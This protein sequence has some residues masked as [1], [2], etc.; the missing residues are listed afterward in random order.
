VTP[1]GKVRA[2]LRKQALAHGL[3]HRKLSWK[4]RVGAP[5]ELLFVAH[6]LVPRIALVEVKRLGETPEPHQEREI[7]RL[8]KAGFDVWVVDSEAGCDQVILSL[9]ECKS[10]LD[11]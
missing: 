4:G 2:Y 9:M 11:N 1:E 3:E 10:A 5:D 6:G 8:R 7:A